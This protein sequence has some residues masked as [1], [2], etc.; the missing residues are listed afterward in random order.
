MTNKTTHIQCTMYSQHRTRT[1]N[2]S[3]TSL[4]NPIT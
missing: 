2:S 1:Q 3:S 4:Q